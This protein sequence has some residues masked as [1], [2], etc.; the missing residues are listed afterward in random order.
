MTDQN[1][2][3][4]GGRTPGWIKAALIASLVVN[5]AVIGLFIGASMKLKERRGG[6]A[7][8]QIEWIL[9]LVP[10]DRHA[11]TKE[12]F[13]AKRDDLRKARADRARHMEAIVAAIGELRK[14]IARNW[15]T[16]P[17]SSR[18]RTSRSSPR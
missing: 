18:I 12:K 15:G 10:D 13:E 1:A 2:D 17:K 14:G 8:Q 7:N 3:N 16:S 9:R 11:F 4:T 6:G 5:V